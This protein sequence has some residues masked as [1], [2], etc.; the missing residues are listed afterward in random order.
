MT[1]LNWVLLL[2]YAGL[3][4]WSGHWLGKL[5]V[6]LIRYCKPEGKLYVFFV[7]KICGRYFPQCR[8]RIYQRR[9]QKR[10]KEIKKF[11]EKKGIS[12]EKYDAETEEIFKL[13]AA[14]YFRQ[15]TFYE[16]G[17]SE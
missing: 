10:D 5:F 2:G 16:T 8:T 3:G 14:Y 13:Y 15:K 17:G 7:D 4:V 6:L 12:R 1:D 9:I 11:C